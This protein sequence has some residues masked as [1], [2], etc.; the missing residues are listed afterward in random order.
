MTQFLSFLPEI[1]YVYGIEI[2]VLLSIIIFVLYIFYS[3][4]LFKKQ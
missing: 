1:N 4:N 3:L 2:F